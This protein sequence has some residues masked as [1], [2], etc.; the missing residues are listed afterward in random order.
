MHAYRTVLIA[1]TALTIT[2]A[3]SGCVSTAPVSGA[4][5]EKLAPQTVDAAGQAFE[6]GDWELF[7]EE[8]A[9]DVPMCQKS[10][11][12]WRDG[13]VPPELSSVT[14]TSEALSE[15]TRRVTFTGKL[16]NGE[17]FSSETELLNPGTGEPRFVDPVFWVPR[18][19]SPA[20]KS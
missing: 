11:A 10:I 4:D 19:I 5:V 3:A 7:C 18:T 13:G 12:A 9:A 15:N 8:W 17:D 20:P 16:T 1:I 14:F 2:V 6:S